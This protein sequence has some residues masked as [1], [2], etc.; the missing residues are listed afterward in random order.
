MVFLCDGQSLALVYLWLTLIL[1][2]QPTDCFISHICTK[3]HFSITSSCVL[4]T[5]FHPSRT[6]A[7]YCCVCVDVLRACTVEMEQ[8]C[9]LTYSLFWPSAL[10]RATQWH[11]NTTLLFYRQNKTL[12]TATLLRPSARNSKRRQPSW[13]KS[14][15]NFFSFSRSSSL[16]V[17]LE[18]ATQRSRSACTQRPN[19]YYNKCTAP[20]GWDDK[21]PAGPS[22]TL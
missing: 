1:S 9:R 8:I 20:M 10:C 13:P 6:V 18:F 14:S 4:T 19:H 21:P 11:N 3:F 5:P 16:T 12:Y 2:P 15:V 7:C 17:G 22:N